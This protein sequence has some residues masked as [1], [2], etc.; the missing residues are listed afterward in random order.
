[1]EES[2]QPQRPQPPAPKDTRDGYVPPRRSQ[3]SE[4]GLLE[5]LV[6]EPADYEGAGWVLTEN[7]KRD[8]SRLLEGKPG[9]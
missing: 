6:G 5:V 3:E 8:L 4:G 2:S 9:G 7:G 1:M